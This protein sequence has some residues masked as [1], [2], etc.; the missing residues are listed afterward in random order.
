MPVVPGYASDHGHVTNLVL[1]TL[2][3]PA[4]RCPKGGASPM[5]AAQM[6]CPGEAVAGPCGPE[7]IGDLQRGGPH[8]A[9]AVA[10]RL[11]VDQ[12]CDLVERTADGPH[13]PRRHLGVQRG[14][15]E[16]GMAEQNLHGRAEPG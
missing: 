15:V 14:V 9:S 3:Y 2:S 8:D 16:L 11:L 13:R 5:R 4:R 10:L 7:D 12:A 6:P 1:A